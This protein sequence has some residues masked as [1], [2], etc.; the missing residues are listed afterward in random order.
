MDNLICTE[1]GVTYYSA[2]AVAML[3]RGERCDCGGLL[4]T[5]G[6]DGVAV[7]VPAR[8]ADADRPAPPGRFGRP[9]RE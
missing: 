2:A 6:A 8:P 9:P 1:C 3:A 4:A 5:L 7:G